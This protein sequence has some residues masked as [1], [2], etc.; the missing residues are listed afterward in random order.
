MFLHLGGDVV[1][2]FRD[3]VAIFDMEIRNQSRSTDEFLKVVQEEGFVKDISDGNP[4][5]FVITNKYVY[6]SAISSLT[7]KK[8]ADFL[9]DYLEKGDQTEIKG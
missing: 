8:R 7:L 5:S 9:K 2:P 3:V 6:L 4:K 1:I